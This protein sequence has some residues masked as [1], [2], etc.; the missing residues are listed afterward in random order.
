M[1]YT[2]ER[3]GRTEHVGYSK[4]SENMQ[5]KGIT[6]LGRIPGSGNVKYHMSLGNGF[7]ETPTQAF[8]R[9]PPPEKIL[10]Q[11]MEVIFNDQ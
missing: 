6:D 8:H 11:A 5:E 4:S 9:K 7:Y 10:G 1:D 2:R 3:E